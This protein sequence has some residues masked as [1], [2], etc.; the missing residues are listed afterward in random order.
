MTIPLRKSGHALHTFPPIAEQQREYDVTGF[1]CME[2]TIAHIH[3]WL[4]GEAE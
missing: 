1:L 4:V 3:N 2:V